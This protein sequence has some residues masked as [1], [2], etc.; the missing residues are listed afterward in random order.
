M[1]KQSKR[2]KI[3]RASHPEGLVSFFADEVQ[4][5]RVVR[6]ISLRD[7]CEVSGLSPSALSKFIHER[8]NL[9]TIFTLH[10]I[11]KSLDTSIT[12]LLQKFESPP[13]QNQP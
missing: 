12:E 7:L 5:R 6:E 8:G 9:P 3:G 10:R 4:R 1:A 2:P 13:H 11:L